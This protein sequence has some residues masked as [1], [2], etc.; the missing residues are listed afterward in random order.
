MTD[1][2]KE[3]ALRCRKCGKYKSHAEFRPPIEDPLQAVCNQCAEYVPG[4]G[5]LGMPVTAAKQRSESVAL[6]PLEKKQAID[7]AWLSISMAVIRMSKLLCDRQKVLA[8]Q[9]RVDI[10]WGR[11]VEARKQQKL[12]KALA[13]RR[14]RIAETKEK[15]EK[16]LRQTELL[17]Q[18]TYRTEAFVSLQRLH[19]E[20]LRK[21]AETMR[22]ELDAMNARIDMGSQVGRA[23]EEAVI[24]ER[25]LREQRD[26]DEWTYKA[27]LTTDPTL[28]TVYLSRAEGQPADDDE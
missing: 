10:L 7:G 3:A 28:R 12:D 4:T 21:T 14:E 8:K 2:M 25:T 18:R 5:G 1:L 24:S 11:I 17:R 13:D 26:R 6:T 19:A 22:A 9:R 23:M 20:E 15:T 27:N 16:L